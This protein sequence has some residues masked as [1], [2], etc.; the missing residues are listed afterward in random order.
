MRESNGLFQKLTQRF[1]D[2][3]LAMETSFGEPVVRIDKATV[4]DVLSF[5]KEDVELSYNM[6]VEL[7]GIDCLGEDPRF[8]V[9][10]ILRSMRTNQRV[11]IRTR[12][13]EDGLDSV[14]DMW[15][16]ADWLEREIYDMLGIRFNNHPNLCRIYND[17]GF[18]GY[19]LRKDYPTEGYDFDK[20]FVVKLE[21]EKA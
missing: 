17:D 4:R 20:P 2:M 5:L 12:A 15:K 1:G 3:S 14:S 18:E 13:G 9:V 10:Y 8:E 6:L 7:F 19:P 11:T 16:A 21:E